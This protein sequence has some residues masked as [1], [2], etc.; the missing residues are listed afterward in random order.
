MHKCAIVGGACH[1]VSELV[2]CWEMAPQGFLVVHA[3]HGV[4]GAD[5][6]SKTCIPHIAGVR[7]VIFG[8]LVVQQNRIGISVL[9][10]R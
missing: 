3:F 7:K 9:V 8:V 5:A 6:P 1:S 10:G 4:Y 2:S